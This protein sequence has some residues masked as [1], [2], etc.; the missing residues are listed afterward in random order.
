MDLFDR[1]F[2]HLKL[3]NMGDYQ[4][5]ESSSESAGCCLT[6]SGV[7]QKLADTR[8]G[9]LGLRDDEQMALI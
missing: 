9:Q 7:G 6:R 1:Y 3:V 5:S 4:D 8:R 2:L